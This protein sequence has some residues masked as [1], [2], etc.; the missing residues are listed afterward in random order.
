MLFSSMTFLWIFFPIV[1]IGTLLIKDKYQN[2]FLLLASLFFYAWGEPIYVI[3][4]LF[5]ILLNWG[6][7]NLIEN[8]PK[9]KRGF[10]VVCISINLMLLGYYKYYNFF[11]ESL[12]K[13]FNGSFIIPTREIALPIGISFFTF[14]AL[15]YVIDLY[16]GNCKV[17]RNI[18]NLA[19]YVSFFPQLIAGP[20]VRYRDIDEQIQCRSITVE[21][22]AEGFRRFIYGLGKKVIISNC[23][24]EIVDK[25]IAQDISNLTTV[26]AW[27][28]AICYT[29]QIY[30]DFSGYSDM[31][32]GLGKIF[33]FD[34]LENFN[35][36][37]LSRSI[38]EFWQRWHMSLGSWFREYVY[39]PLGGNRKG[40]VRTY[41]NL[42]IVFFLTGMWHGASWNFIVW[43]LYHGFFQ[44]I[45]RLGFQKILKKYKVFSHIYCMLV[46]IV[47]WVFFR[48]ESL[49]DGLRIVARM[50]MPWKYAFYSIEELI[51]FLAIRKVLIIFFAII[52]SGLIYSLGL[53][54]P[55][56]SNKWKNS[57]YET[58]FCG[59]MLLYCIMQLASGTYNPFIYFRF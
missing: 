58:V 39:F 38:H 50:F 44:I 15:S 17:Q 34:F 36:P 28:V 40:N 46:V 35:Y 24:A 12:N 9:Y 13:I 26:G 4:M 7:G 2:I 37:Y 32:I 56:I 41:V 18:L 8:V 23:C 5:S 43:G 47:G 6:F 57:I 31:A 11:V 27:I 55:R 19:L 14:Q 1:V 54:F 29:L 21:K 42:C 59:M 3:L 45:E 52:G 51:P 48:M 16:R 53:K 22:F 33:G 49:R 20:I 25:L 30:Y 10:L